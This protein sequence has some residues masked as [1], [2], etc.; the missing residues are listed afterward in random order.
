MVID[1]LTRT[2]LA[3]V[4][5]TAACAGADELDESADV[6]VLRPLIERG[7]R[8]TWCHVVRG[9]IRNS[10]KRACARSSANW[11]GRSKKNY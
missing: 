10:P 2:V 9:K 8:L 3:V 4:I 7:V 11:L 6:G 5:L 1:R